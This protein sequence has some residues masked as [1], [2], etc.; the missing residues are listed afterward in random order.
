M[1]NHHADYLDKRFGIMLFLRGLRIFAV[2]LPFCSRLM[3]EI[4]NQDEVGKIFAETSLQS[5]ATVTQRNYLLNVL[6]LSRSNLLFGQSA[7]SSVFT[8]QSS[9]PM[10]ITRLPGYFRI[11]V[12]ITSRFQ[13]SRAVILRAVSSPTADGNTELIFTR[14]LRITSAHE[15][16]ELSKQQH[17]ITPNR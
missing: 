10:F 15:P 6:T 11:C 16:Q 9:P 1:L 5:F 12:R 14:V 2:R 7:Q 13:G 4:Q 17:H 3:D 8:V